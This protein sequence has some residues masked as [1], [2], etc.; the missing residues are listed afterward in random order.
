MEDYRSSPSKRPTKRKLGED[1]A[2]I[3]AAYCKFGTGPGNPQDIFV[4]TIS[5]FASMIAQRVDLLYFVEL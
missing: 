4:Q 5:R 1:Q 3:A 2:N